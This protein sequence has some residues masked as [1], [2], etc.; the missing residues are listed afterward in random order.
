MLLADM[1]AEVVKIEPPWGDATRSSPQYPEVKGQNTYFM[2]VNRNKKSLVLN[3]KSEKGI[4]VLKKLVEQSDILVENFRPGVMDRLGIGYD[5]LKKINPE[6]IYAS[7]SGF[8]QDGVYSKRPSF[9]IV[10]QAMSGWMWLNSQEIRGLNSGPS[11]VP[12]TLA[13]SPGD[14]IPGTFCA[15]SILAALLYRKETGHGQRIDVPQVNSLMTISGL[16]HTRYLFTGLT[17]KQRAHQKNTMIHGVYEAKDGFVVLRAFNKKALNFLATTIGMDVEFL[18]P[19]SKN[20]I[21]WLKERTRHEILELL[22]ENIPCAS[23][24]TEE[25]LVNDPNVLEQEMIIEENHP[26]GFKYRAMK[27]GIKFSETP[28][29]FELHPPLLGENSK[30]LLLKLGYDEIQI[31]KMVNENVTAGISLA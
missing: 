29:S 9:D 3:L 20:L 27:T 23:V 17:A 5:A 28:V 22:A 19:S 15:M 21:N 26:L 24:L 6:L 7:I 31:S 10:A 2:F 18:S 1:G 4:E 25:E 11:F 30:E 14:T 16:A 12:S 8:G 13:G